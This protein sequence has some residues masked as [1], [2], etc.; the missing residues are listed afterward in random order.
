MK[1]VILTL[2]RE[3]GDL[4]HIYKNELDKACFLYDPAYS[5]SKDLPKKSISDKT[6]K[7]TVNEI[8]MNPKK[9]LISKRTSKYCL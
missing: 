4:K 1:L 5:D 7:D 8:A 9:W 6:L 2:L 3:T